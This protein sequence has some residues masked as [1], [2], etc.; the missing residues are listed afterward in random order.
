MSQP[1]YSP[2]ATALLQVVSGLLFLLVIIFIIVAYFFLATPYFY[3]WVGLLS[4][5]PLL[6]LFSGLP[7]YSMIIAL[8]VPTLKTPFKSVVYILLVKG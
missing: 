6:F 4:R 2:A 1:A 5:L 3:F 7:A 8:H